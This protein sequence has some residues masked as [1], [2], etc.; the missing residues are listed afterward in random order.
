[1]IMH[2]KDKLHLILFTGKSCSVCHALK[3]KLK[4]LLE[5]S[6]PEI[7]LETI[8]LEEEPKKSAEHMV[9]SLPVL[10]IMVDGKEYYRFKGAFSLVEVEN[11]IKRLKA[12]IED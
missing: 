8:D 3:P 2:K 12:I 7:R 1:M 4:A 9:F 5:N 10:L 11:N 6:Y